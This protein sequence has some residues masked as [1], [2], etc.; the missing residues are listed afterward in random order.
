[1]HCDPTESLFLSESF[2]FVLCEVND[3]NAFDEDIDH[4]T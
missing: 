1:M 3:D 4:I 2:W